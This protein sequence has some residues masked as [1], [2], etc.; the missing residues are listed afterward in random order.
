MQ[1][2]IFNFDELRFEPYADDRAVAE[3]LAH[4]ASGATIVHRDDA[5]ALT[6]IEAGAAQAWAHDEVLE[7]AGVVVRPHQ[8]GWLVR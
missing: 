5:G 2:W 8:L 4:T 6:V 1:A 7:I 3:L